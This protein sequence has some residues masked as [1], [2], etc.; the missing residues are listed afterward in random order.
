MG[1]L[2]CLTSPSGKKYIG[3][4]RFTL[5]QRWK[6]HIHRARSKVRKTPLYAAMRKYGPDSFSVRALVIADWSYLNELESRAIQAL[7]TSYPHG[8][9]L[10]PGGHLVEWHPESKAKMRHYAL[11]MPAEHRLKISQAKMGHD[12]SPETRRKLSQARKGKPWSQRRRDA[13]LEK[14]KVA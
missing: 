4:T 6:S 2:Y 1:V 5:E 9:N 3:I 12:V 7:R 14:G 10:A 11:N 13:Q 8:Y